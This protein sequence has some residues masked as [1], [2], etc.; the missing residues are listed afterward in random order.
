MNVI[1][2]SACLPEGDSEDF[3]EEEEEDEEDVVAAEEDD[4][5]S[6]DE[7]VSLVFNE[8]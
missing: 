2:D 7:E 1:Y 8:V 4:D 5:D 6:A 3:E